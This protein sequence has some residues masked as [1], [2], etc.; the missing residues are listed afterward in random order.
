MATSSLWQEEV[1]FSELEIRDMMMKKI[2]CC[3]LCRGVL[4]A[5][6]VL[7]CCP[8]VNAQW[9][10]TSYFMDAAQYRL[11]LN[12]ALAPEK[13]FVHLPGIGHVNA[14]VRSNTLGFDDVLDIIENSDDADYFASDRFV[15]NLEDDNRALVNAGCDL[16]AVGWW[17]SPRS[18]WTINMSVK[19][20]GDMN[21]QR[22]LFSFLRDMRG[23][24]T[25]DYTN[26]VRDVGEH[27]LNIN[28]YTEIAVGYTR[29]FSDRLSAG[30]RVK[31]LLGLG[32]AHLKVNK[33]VVRTNLQG[34]DP[35]ID[36]SRA[37]PD[38]LMDAQGTAQVEVDATLESSIEGLELLTS[39]YGYVDELD[40]D[41]KHMGVSGVGAGFDVGVAGRV[42][43]GLSL[44][45][46]LVDVGF[47][48]WSRG[49]TTVA[50][51]N[52]EDL[53]F[54]SNNPG[55]VG[56]FSD[57]VGSGETLNLD[58]LRLYVDEDAAR[59]RTTRLNSSLVLGADYSFAGDKLSLG[60]L[61]TN[62]FARIK[63]ESEVTMSVNYKPSRLVGLTASYS[64]IVCGGQSFGFG[65]KLGPL[66][67]G[68]DY[69][70]TGMKTKCCNALFGLSIPLGR[71]QD[72]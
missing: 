35:D 56:R 28:A 14:A 51:S 29:R 40:F 32:N 53:N 24:Q 5:V 57:I 13:G 38:Q 44:S 25:N 58:M 6:L 10:R 55:D 49:S 27:E 12:P 18:F 16:L 59:S 9:L 15:S 20:D 54:D 41:A 60:L 69:M 68:T 43:G 2:S 26:Y 48:K 31:G 8:P 61:Y 67:V 45:A 65:I 22:G 62:Y 72:N 70:F 52:T 46:A 21:V 42:V 17:Q 19:V 23:L 47:I 30:L 1:A 34:V 4:A 33:A 66:F 3:W 63:G 71:R 37:T 39:N 7:A 50:Q 11:Q 36:W 64:P